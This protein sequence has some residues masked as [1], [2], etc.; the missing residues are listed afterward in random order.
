M[1]YCVS[2]KAVRQFENLFQQSITSREILS[3]SSFLR[4]EAQHTKFTVTAN[5]L[6]DTPQ[7]AKLWYRHPAPLYCFGL[8]RLVCQRS[9]GLGSK[10]T[11]PA[12]DAGTCWIL[13][14]QIICA[15]SCVRRFLIFAVSNGRALL[16]LGEHPAQTP[17]TRTQ[18]LS[19]TNKKHVFFGAC[20]A[21]C[22]L[23]EM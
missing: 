22:L 12:E 18:R 10:F 3:H 15:R 4:F 7:Q 19:E 2:F 13:I 6:A 1:C 21:K 17:L 14:T 23:V 16:V 11:Q 5:H 20:G 8:V 9:V